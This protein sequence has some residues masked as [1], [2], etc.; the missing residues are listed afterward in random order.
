MPRSSST[1]ACRTRSIRSQGLS[2]TAAATFAQ[3]RQGEAEGLLAALD[4]GGP[5]RRAVELLRDPSLRPNMALHPE[6]R[7]QTPLE[8]IEPDLD[9]AIPEA[10]TTARQ[11][12]DTLGRGALETGRD[13]NGRELGVAGRRKDDAFAA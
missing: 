2:L 5:A 7:R 11:A 3:Q 8:F 10:T 9:D 13:P 6:Q 4:L 1:S 12:R